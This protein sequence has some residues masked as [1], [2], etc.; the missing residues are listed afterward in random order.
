MPWPHP[1]VFIYGILESLHFFA[2]F[3]TSWPH[4]TVSN[5]DLGAIYLICH[6]Q[7]FMATFSCIHIARVFWR[8]HTLFAIFSVPWPHSTAFILRYLEALTLFAIFSVSWLHYT[9]FILDLLEAVHFICHFQCFMAP[10]L[11][12]QLGLLEAMHFICHFQCFMAP[13]H[14]IYLGSSGGYPLCLPFS[15][16]H[17]TIPLYSSRILWRL[18]AL[19]AILQCFM[20]QSH[21]FW[22]LYTL[23]AI[24]LLNCLI[25]LYSTRVFWRLYTLFAIFSASW[26]HSTAF[27]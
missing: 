10:F 9:V 1:T 15:G 12:I 24:L 8:L 17:G 7:C 3:S 19:F 2:I 4:S 27:I 14:C 26:P 16:L 25:S 20:A 23:V 22:R 11:C 18:Y 21:C 6:F 5:Q 13:L